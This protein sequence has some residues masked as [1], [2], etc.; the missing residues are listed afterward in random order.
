M[1]ACIGFNK[2][3]DTA[4]EAGKYQQKS[5]S[6]VPGYKTGMVFKIL[7]SHKSYFTEIRELP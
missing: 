1:S 2:I 7:F 5:Y 3:N 6:M 4:N